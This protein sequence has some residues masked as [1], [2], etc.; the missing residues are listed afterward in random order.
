MYRDNT[1]TYCP[2]CTETL[3]LHT[4]TNTSCNVT[5]SRYVNGAQI[6]HYEPYTETHQ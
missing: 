5:T 4:C 6:T 3:A 2:N 1:V